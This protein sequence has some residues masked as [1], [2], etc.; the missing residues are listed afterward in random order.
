M[1]RLYKVVHSFWFSAIAVVL[2]LTI[3]FSQADHKYGYT[4]AKEKG[5][6]PVLSDGGAYYAYLPQYIVYPDSTN[7]SFFNDIQRKY[8]QYNFSDMLSFQAGDNIAGNKFYIGTAL[9][10]SPFYYVAHQL[11]LWNDWDA[12]GYQLGYRFSIQ[13]A[14]LFYWL[15]GVIALF[16]LFGRLGFQR[17]TI[18]LGIAAITFGTNLNMYTSY[19][20]SMSHVYSFAMVACFLNASH[21][22]ATEERKWSLAWM[23]LFIALV[24]VIR[25]VN[26]LVIL[27]VPFL[28]PTLKAFWERVKRVFLVDWVV[29]PLTLILGILPIL[30]QLSVVHDQTGQWS[31]YTYSSEGF[32]NA[33]TPQFWNV[34]FSYHKG[35]FVYGPVM[36]LSLPGIYFFYKKGERNLFFGWCITLFIWLYAICSWWCWDYGGGLGMRA[37]IEFLPLFLFPLLY[38]F[39]YARPW[40]QIGVAVIS[41]YCV[42][43]Y[44]VFQFQINHNILHATDMDKETFWSIFGKTDLRYRWM[45]DFNKMR[46]KLPEQEWSKK[47]S[48]H[49]EK[50]GWK[51]LQPEGASISADEFMG[52]PLL[53][54]SPAGNEKV[55]AGRFTG[56]VRLGDPDKNPFLGMRYFSEGDLVEETFLTIGSKIDDPYTYEAFSLDIYHSLEGKNITRVEFIY[57]A[58]G[59][60]IA[61]RNAMLEGYETDR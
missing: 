8:P 26:V 22:W 18:L 55:V 14:A 20:V 35:F 54:Y 30:L 42:F 31:L 16:R 46:E 7:F 9:L 38:L 2:M 41:G 51:E 13:L 3:L 23:A 37:M 52:I 4:S 34:L 12:D 32:T 17:F 33:L 1:Q 29:V 43:L 57:N 39:K 53:N 44:Q 60:D 36:F 15:I 11:H 21:R 28:F 49:F 50:D 27:I 10:Q 58:A 40:M 48:A 19:W 47:W 61:I 6:T 5:E 56:E 45:I 24:A 25:P 59:G